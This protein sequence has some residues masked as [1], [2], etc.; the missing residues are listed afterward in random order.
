MST[1]LYKHKLIYSQHHLSIPLVY[2]SR[3]FVYIC[4]RIVTASAICEVRSTLF[5]PNDYEVHVYSNFAYSSFR[6]RM[7]G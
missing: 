2:E 7:E 1:F 5:I 3:E 6:V 4:S